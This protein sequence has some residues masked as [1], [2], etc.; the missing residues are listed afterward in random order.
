MFTIICLVVLSGYFHIIFFLI[1]F[2]RESLAFGSRGD[3]NVECPPQDHEF[4]HLILPCWWCCLGRSRSFAG[5][6]HC[7]VDSKALS[8]APYFLLPLFPG[9]RCSMARQ[10]PAPAATPSLLVALEQ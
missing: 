9:H 1:S 8:P 10:P 5:G 7:G 3:L 6:S 4:E 2:L